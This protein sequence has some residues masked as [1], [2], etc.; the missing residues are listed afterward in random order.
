MS[1]CLI[2]GAGDPPSLSLF[3]QEKQKADI[4][5]AADGG[6]N[7]LYQNFIVPN[8]LIG[9]FDSIDE[10]ALNYFIA[11]KVNVVR[12]PRE[13]TQTDLQLALCEA[14]VQ[15]VKNVVFLGCFGK[16]IDHVFGNVHI[17]FDCLCHDI[18]AQI[19]SDDK[20]LKIIKKPTTIEG[21]A[22]QK[23]SL[24]AYVG[25]VEKLNIKGSKYELENYDLQFGELLTLSNE[26]LAQK[27]EISFQSGFLL[28]VQHV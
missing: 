16:D 11:Q 27:V 1:K 28:L 5:I 12:Y 23:F 21:R 15:N 9:D 18:D 10:S 7:F 24:L 8:F 17:L 25:A 19:K 3:Q 6:G 20:I 26:F 14:K 2:I 13:K 4:V 22:G